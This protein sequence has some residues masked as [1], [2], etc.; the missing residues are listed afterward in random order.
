MQVLHDTAG[1]RRT[2]AK[3]ARPAL[4]L[5]PPG[6]LVVCGADR[7]RLFARYPGASVDLCTGHVMST[8]CRKGLIW[9][10]SPLLPRD[11]TL[12]SRR[13][14]MRLPILLPLQKGS[15]KSQCP[16]TTAEKQA[17][18]AADGTNK[19]PFQARTRDGLDIIPSGQR[20]AVGGHLHSMHTALGF[21]TFM[22]RP[23]GRRT[24]SPCGSHG[25]FVD[26]QTP[27]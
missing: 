5:L 2:A 24:R 18:A 1:S 11:S 16:L 12:L 13:F 4:A 17:L 14:G 22:D 8:W 20:G 9:R 7:H 6:H 27:R 25:P 26:R 15:T 23:P 10:S 21:I 3:P 19:T